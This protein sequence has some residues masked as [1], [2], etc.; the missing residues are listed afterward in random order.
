MS[1]EANLLR[2]LEP[3]VRPTGSPSPQVRSRPSVEGQSFNELLDQASRSPQPD[4]VAI[5]PE[6]AD[7]LAGL[8]VSLDESQLRGIGEATDRA[9]AHGAREILVMLDQ[10]NVVVDVASR[11]IITAA[12]RASLQND[13]ITNIDS[14]VSVRPVEQ[15][16]LNRLSL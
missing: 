8:G 7:R 5:A 6:A 11:T 10:F 4:Q 12:D 3:S 15:E 16:P 13:V 2:L 1:S 14:A 9:Q